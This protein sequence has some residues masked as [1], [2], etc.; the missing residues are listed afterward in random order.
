MTEDQVSKAMKTLAIKKEN[1]M[2]ARVILHNMRQDCDK[3][4]RAFGVRLRGQAS[5][6]KFTQKCP[7]CEADVDYTEAMITT[8]TF[9]SQQEC[10]WIHTQSPTFSGGKV[11]SISLGGVLAPPLV[12]IGTP[13]MFCVGC[14]RMGVRSF[15]GLPNTHI[16]EDIFVVGSSIGELLPRMQQ[17]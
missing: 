8:D 17:C 9:L 1:T 10:Q 15:T 4:V 5:V 14:I 6:C 7:S 11:R 13:F 3:P 16:A 12:G 2:V